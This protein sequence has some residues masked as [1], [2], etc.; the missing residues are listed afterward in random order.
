MMMSGGRQPLAT[1]P[2]AARGPA[3]NP[4]PVSRTSTTIVGSSGFRR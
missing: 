3:Y 4:G 2:M 1:A